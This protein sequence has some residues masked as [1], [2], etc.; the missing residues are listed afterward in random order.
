MDATG[1]PQVDSIVIG[2]GIAGLAAALTL[3][4]AGREVLVIDPSDR[5]G[6]VMRTDHVSGYV[7]ER[8]PQ[9]TLVKGPMLSFL[10]ARGLED[11]MLRAAPA[12]RLRLI[13]RDGCLQPVPMSPLA[14]A[15]TPLLSARGKL[16]LLAE[17]FVRRGQPAGESVA[18]FMSRRLGAELVSGLVG[19]F[20]TGVYA[21][22]EER[23]GAAA[24]FGQLVSLEERYGSIVTGALR[25]GMRPPGGRGLRGSHSTQQGFGP[26]AR[27]LA[28]LLSEPPALGTR[29]TRVAPHGVGWRV[30]VTSASGDSSLLARSVV[31]AAPSLDAAAVL[32]GVDGEAADVLER[33]EYAPIVAVPVGVD[34]SDVRERIEGFGFLVPREEELGLLG[35][36]FMSRLFPGRAPDGR[37]LLHCMLG[38]VRWPEAVHVPDDVIVKRLLAD[39]E[40]T[41]GLRGEPQVLAIARWH[42]AVPQ[43]D[44]EHPRRM[45]EVRERLGG[46]PGLALAGAYLDGVSVADSLASGVRAASELLGR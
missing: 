11:A 30:D 20:L 17:P 35:C 32:R 42:R 22:D 33:I 14:L 27:R 12:S 19:P 24:V 34:P 21:G 25:G 36:L 28:D 29:V 10:K 8:G 18:E 9:T 13:Y 44:R 45:R 15:R 3:Q 31:V 2:A 40:R 26:F 6:G 5:P 43:P 38:G 46:A 16:R 23:L 41:L 1:T 37:E 39:L 4:E 7:I